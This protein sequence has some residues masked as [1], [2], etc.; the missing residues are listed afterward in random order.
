MPTL[1]IIADTHIPQRL[2][3]LPDGIERAFRGVDLILHAGDLNSLRVLDDLNQIA[4]TL[5]VVGNA[6]LFGT[7]LPRR[8]IVEVGG[9]HIGLTHGHGSWPRYLM[10]KVIEAFSYDN[11][12]YARAARAEFA[13]DDVSAVVF[14]HTHRAHYQTIDG[15]L[16]FNPGP[17]APT[18]YNTRG[19]QVGLLRIETDR[20]SAE[21]IE[22]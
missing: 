11:D 5:A 8:R 12:F 22:L 14:G 6:D 13:S 18:Y 21:V 4:P 3:R 7:G 9:R 15:V 19:P 1:G 20:L 17:I 2:A 16:L 10:R